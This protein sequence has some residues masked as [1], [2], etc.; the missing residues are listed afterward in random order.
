[1]SWAYVC[2]A[3][4]LLDRF[5]DL[6]VFVREGVVLGL[7]HSVVAFLFCFGLVGGA[8]LGWICWLGLDGNAFVGEHLLEGLI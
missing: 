6:W 1:M 5:P 7:G 2:E 3:V 8:G 4:H